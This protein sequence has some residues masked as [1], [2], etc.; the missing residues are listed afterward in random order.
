M[1]SCANA[2]TAAAGSRL[3]PVPRA[4]RTRGSVPTPTESPS[5]AR[6]EEKE[7]AMRRRVGHIRQRSPDSFEVRYSLGTN[8][9]T[10]KRKTA[11]VTVRG[12]RKD[13]ERELRKHLVAVDK[14]ER[15]DST[16][17]TA[18]EWF[19]RWLSITK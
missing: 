11:T 4:E 2:C 18:G 16:K 15:A 5:T 12:T 8:P 1:L 17:I 7:T 19:D 14:G 3:G 9:A 6:S 13:A 10:G